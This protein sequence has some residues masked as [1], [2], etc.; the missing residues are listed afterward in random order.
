M[1]KNVSLRP[2]TNNGKPTWVLLGPDGRPIPAFSAYAYALRNAATNTLDSYCRHLAEFMDYLI[3]VSA[4]HEGQLT[5]LQLSEA[6]EAYG[7]YLELGLDARS[8][9]ARTVAARLPPGVNSATSLARIFHD[10]E[11][12]S[13]VPKRVVIGLL[14]PMATEDCRCQSVRTTR[15]TSAAW[16]AG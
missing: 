10:L 13:L 16:A 15:S 7:D 6:I 5:K 1:F 9:L 4:L 8:D 2:R 12:G 14:P 3:E 11:V